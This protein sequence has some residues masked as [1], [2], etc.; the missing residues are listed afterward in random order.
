[1][2]AATNPWSSSTE[3]HDWGSIF[4]FSL[5]S[6]LLGEI[7]LLHNSPERFNNFL[8][9]LFIPYGLYFYIFFH[10]PDWPLNQLFVIQI[11]VYLS[12]FSKE[13]YKFFESKSIFFTFFSPYSINGG[14][15]IFL[16]FKHLTLPDLSIPTVSSYSNLKERV[17]FH[18]SVYPR[19][20]L[21]PNPPGPFPM[22]SDWSAFLSSSL[23]FWTSPST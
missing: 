1:M 4:L 22:T 10:G 17:S 3:L 9:P 7:P 20:R 12:V 11:Y 8:Y 13:K 5:L 6:T 15:M 23:K 18:L 21:S 19:S 2:G 14:Q 16:L